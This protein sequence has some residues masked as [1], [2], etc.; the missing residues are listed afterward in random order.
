MS[1]SSHSTT[2]SS[3][4][5]ATKLTAALGPQLADP[6]FM[7]ALRALAGGDP[8]TAETLSEATG[9]PVPT[10][11]ARLAAAP[12]L[13]TD[14]AGR[15]VGAAL[16][17]VPTSHRVHLGDKTLY[18]WC[19]F[20]LLL[21]PQILGESLE[22]ETVDPV[23]GEAIQVA[24]APHGV[25]AVSP[26]GVVATLVTPDADAVCCGVRGAFCDYAH[27]FGSEGAA[28]GWL[29]ERG[30]EARGLTLP[31]DQAFEVARLLLRHAGISDGGQTTGDST[32]EAASHRAQPTSDRD[33]RTTDDGVTMRVNLKVQG[34]TCLDCATH[35]E[36]VLRKLPG[37][38]S[39]TVD[40][41]A[42]RGAV[43]ASEN[44]PSSELVAAVE[45]A[46]YRAAVIGENGLERRE[47]GAEAAPSGL[48]RTLGRKLGYGGR[49]AAP[50]DASPVTVAPG[51]SASG[52]PS[53]A[54]EAPL[55]DVQRAGAP[56][57]AASRPA[58]GGANGTSPEFGASD[59]D[60][61]VI[62]TGGAG[63][64]AAI[65]AGSM[66]A[67]VAIAEGGLVGGT[68]VNVGC[69][70]SKNL[71]EAAAHY[72]TARTGFPGI[73]ACEPT[74][75]WTA[76]LR[77]KHD[78]VG[79]LR[80][81]KYV[82][83][84]ASYPTISLVEGRVRILGGGNGTGPVVARL[85]DGAGAREV[86]AAKVIIATGT[87]PA[88]PPLPGLDEVE[89]LDSTTVMELQA[90]PKSM[91]ILGGGPVGVEAAQT[92]ARFGVKVLLV[93]RGARLLPGEEPVVSEALRI[94]LEAE[95]IEVHTGTTATRVERD[96]DQIVVH[97]RQ[98]S[99]DGQFRTE[100]I[101][102]GTGR[103][104]NTG[105]MGLEDAG[106]RLTA[107]GFVEVD[108]T[109]RSTSHPDV[110]A[111]GD[112]TGGPGYVYV[113]AAGGRVA[114]ENA[115]NAL[116]AAAEGQEATDPRE[117]DLSV[118]PNV[119]FTSPQV[120]SVGLTE[121]GAR[122]AGYDVD[123]SSLEMAQV[124]RA[125]VSHHTAGLVKIVAEAESGR[126]L[127][128]HVLSENAGDFI[129]EATL[130]IRFGLTARDLTGTLHPYLTW[131]ESLK[132]A[133]Q[134]FTTDVTKLSCCA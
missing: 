21:L 30:T 8:V 103:R 82:D 29:K 80:Q 126:L 31:L 19:A 5:I 10:M 61:L 48:L 22:A 89:P 120:A 100:R 53:F 13:E 81:A 20:D 84:L 50:R 18:T 108:T 71:I 116:L 129:G 119:T 70:P 38:E 112:V 123:V 17:L 24:V 3:D 115:V 28:V 93:Q 37:V 125:L 41:R 132:L 110:Y 57:V 47:D 124:P 43:D 74:L 109:M 104:P 107:K 134:G 67:R 113:A 9:L 52:T 32:A 1:S 7:A 106:V 122:E 102:V 36:Q 54:G 12:N 11:A 14:E 63:V 75:D 111:A 55:R 44:V 94:A 101:L 133:A 77:Q 96:G 127:G 27:F 114:A 87:A 68:C 56:A 130:A 25:Q 88:A 49:A 46:G 92:F 6:A 78:L 2:T 33:L 35:I 60:V 118:V 85:G 39:A 4:V 65:Q 121:A 128:V 91:L 131:G 66:G 64:A 90:L 16:S 117:F 73:A 51:S 69:I 97:V 15:V 34:M 98:G 59:F 42:G 76:V 26:A 62:G 45:R 105:D 83:V 40:Y 95:G 99:L 72:H 23:T 58:A 79:E 86:R